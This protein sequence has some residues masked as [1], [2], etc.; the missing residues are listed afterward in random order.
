MN[1]DP[2]WRILEVETPSDAAMNLAIDESILIISSKT[3]RSPT[4]RFWRNMKAV[5][6]GYSQ[7]LD[8]EVNLQFCKKEGI[9]VIRRLS[10]GGA[11]YHDL[12]NLN[13]SIIIEQNH[14][15]IKSQD[16]QE[17]YRFLCHGI[18]KGLQALGIK[19]YFKHPNNIFIG[20]KKISGSAQSRKKGIILHH[21]TLLI[22]SD[23]NL[24]K[25]S[26]EP[27]CES[28]GE[29]HG[30]RSRKQPVTNLSLS[31]NHQ[32]NTSIVKEALKHGFE[33]TFSMRLEPHL[34]TKEEMQTAE[35]LKT[36]KYSLKE[37]TLMRH[38]NQAK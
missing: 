33:N 34:P 38:A 36:N 29:Q 32:L 25:R 9:Q 15:L 5:V 13:Y 20:K 37:W 16:I 18:I 30:V 14:P 23:L 3:K 17:S 7:K 28:A 27:D 1:N 6:I 26:L 22:D 31:T 19:T 2:V 4:I 8:L 35:D 11:V 10:G 24:L 21:G 12:G